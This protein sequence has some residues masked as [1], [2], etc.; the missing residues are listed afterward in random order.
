VLGATDSVAGLCRYVL[1]LRLAATL[2]LVVAAALIDPE[3]VRL[4]IGTLIAATVTS[5]ELFVLTRRPSAVTHGW[6]FILVELAAGAAI[7]TVMQGGPVYFSFSCGSAA[8]LGVVMGVRAGPVWV[9]QT[10]AGYLVVA[11]VIRAGEVPSSLAVY[12]TGVPTLYVLVGLAA[13]S[14]RT[15]VLR[16]VTLART[17]LDAIERSAVA[18]ER[19]RM[20]RELHDSVEKTLRGLSFAASALPA[21][22]RRR[23][24]MVDELAATV[25]QGALTAADEARELLGA[26][27]SDDLE[28]GIDQAVASL[29]RTWSAQTGIPA[30]VELTPVEVEMPVRHELLRITREALGNVAKHSGAGRVW[31]V[32]A[33]EPTGL[34]LV[35]QDDGT[36][37]SV[38]GDLN[39]LANAGHYG[40]VGMA[41]RA[42]GVGGR[43]R[44]WSEPSGTQV[45][46][47]APRITDTSLVD[48]AL[49]ASNRA[50]PR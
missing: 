31:V 33:A 49:A 23:P 34:E 47:R 20:A 48:V 37:F 28:A 4:V 29:V 46:I 32:L 14:A 19:G 38:P 15:A 45:V 3:P 25:A 36:G 16:H 17:A 11:W 7:V 9:L 21:S 41:E 22:V 35:V 42:A 12:L 6:G 40:L 39:D 27:R 50:D 26:L 24:E 5:A 30:T 8:V 10:V 18:A 43:L 44:V 1:L 2:M 13:A